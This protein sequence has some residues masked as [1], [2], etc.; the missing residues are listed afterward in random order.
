MSWNYVVTAHKASNVTHSLACH[1]TAPDDLNLVVSKCTHLEIFRVTPEG[2]EPMHDVPLYG[3]IATL[4]VWRPPGAAQ[5]ELFVSTERF[6]FCVLAYEGGDIVTRAHGDLSDRVGK[7]C[8]NGQLCAIE[9]ECRMIGLH[10][11][12]GLFK[13][14]PGKLRSSDDAFNK[15]LEELKV[16]DVAFLHVNPKPTLALLYEDTK[17]LKHLKTNEVLLKEKDFGDG[18][19]Q[20]SQVRPIP[21]P[22][23]RLPRLPSAP[24]SP[25][26]LPP[27]AGGGGR[28]A[29]RPRE[30]LARRPRHRRA[31]DHALQRRRHV[32]S[33]STFRPSRRWAPSIPTAAASS[34]ATTSA[35]SSCSS[36]STSAAR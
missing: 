10:M 11:Y 13:V 24:P 4:E 7:P 27:I 23:R 16:H 34:S 15:L 20:L 22:P 21:S 8:D 3:R 5:D 26:P 31:H 9:P 18:P 36:S 1:F 17:E 2:L 32:T 25:P 35:A 33:P 14:I 29:P 28:R 30:A 12:D 19:W 6:G